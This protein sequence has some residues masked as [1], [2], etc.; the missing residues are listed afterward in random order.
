MSARKSNQAWR[1]AGNDPA[2]RVGGTGRYL[3]EEQIE[4][5]IVCQRRLSERRWAKDSQ[6]LRVSY[7]KSV[8]T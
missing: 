2:T 7:L 3:R 1:S 5:C 4:F 8:H 6:A